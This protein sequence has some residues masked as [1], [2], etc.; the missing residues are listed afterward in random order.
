MLARLLIFFF[1]FALGACAEFEKA[2]APKPLVGEDVSVYD[3]ADGQVEFRM[4]ITGLTSTIWMTTELINK[5]DK[6]V[7]FDSKTL[8]KF[9]DSTCLSKRDF[10]DIPNTI[11][12]PKAHQ[13]LHYSFQLLAKRSNSPEYERCKAQPLRFVV[14][15]LQI[16]AIE[17]KQF[18][19]TIQDEKK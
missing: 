2:T 13:I 3:L 5:S 7:Y 12:K 1:V 6:D 14:S 4:K 10:D 11:L 17:A 19:F 16:N 9:E 8:V 18:S 15:G